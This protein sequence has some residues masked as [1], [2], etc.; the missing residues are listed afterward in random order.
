M[1][2]PEKKIGSIRFSLREYDLPKSISA[3][4]DAAKKKLE[5]EQQKKKVAFSR[6][7][8]GYSIKIVD[9]RR[10][11]MRM[12]SDKYAGLFAYSS[13]GVCVAFVRLPFAKADGTFRA[14][15]TRAIDEFAEGKKFVGY[16]FESPLDGEYSFEK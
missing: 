5:A 15:R 6:I 4:N 9:G 1:N 8:N 10:Y 7:K 13:K 16:E 3:L 14:W 12:F 11:E 2:T